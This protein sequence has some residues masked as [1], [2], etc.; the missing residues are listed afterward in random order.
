MA[1]IRALP[2]EDLKVTARIHLVRNLPSYVRDLVFDVRLQGKVTETEIETLA[3]DAS[4][5]CFFEN[6]LAK[7]MTIVT[8][9]KLNG[10]KL[11]TLN[12][13]PEEESTVSSKVAGSLPPS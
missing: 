11:L 7:T 9:V 13:N 2:I 10:E 5:H 6:T 4:K 1:I 8:E 12:R 3:R